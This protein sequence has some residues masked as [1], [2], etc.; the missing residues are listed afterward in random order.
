M[1]AKRTA[2]IVIWARRLTQG[3]F[4]CLFFWLLWATRF[5]EGAP[6]S[7]WLRLFF[8][9]DP[10]AAAAT[11]LA[12]HAL[13]AFPLLALVTVVATVFLGRVFCGWVCPLG[14]VHTLAS[15]SRKYLRRTPPRRDAWSR[16][17]RAKYYVLAALLVMAVFGAPWIG[18]LDPIPLLYRTTV[19]ALYPGVQYAIEDG[20]TAVYQ[21]DPHLGPLRAKSVTEPAY[22][23]LRDNVFLTK[24]QAFINATAILGIFAAIVLLNL[25]RARFWCRYVCPLGGLLGLL[26]PRP[27]LRLQSAP[28]CTGCG[29]CAVRCPAAADPDKPNGWRATECFGCWNCVAACNNNAI[30]FKFRSPFPAPS[31]AK[32]DLSKRAL[33]S[34]GASGVGGL[35]LFRLSPQAQGR[36]YNPSLI[37]PPG[38]RPEREFV[39]R[40]LQCG[41]C[42]KAC[43]TNGL[44]PALFEA[45]LEGLWTPVLVPR[46]GYCEYNCNLCGQ[47]CP[48]EAIEPLPIEEKKKLRLGLATLDRSRCLPYAYDRECMV[49]EE[50]C[51]V[52]PKAIFFLSQEVQTR[53]GKTAVLK[54]PRVDPDRCTGCGICEN[55]CVFKDRAAIRVT[56]ANETRH[57]GNRAILT[58]PTDLEPEPAGPGPPAE[59]N[60]YAQPSPNPYGSS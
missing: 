57:S 29:R 8:D 22:R 42:M 23:F 52:S 12:A 24:R 43:P 1:S 35:V 45:G 6:P 10:L 36:T 4:L 48:T 9:L 31:T 16:W 53:N 28:G 11:W 2:K 27:V 51:P 44:Q 41:A 18:V 58:G 56:S 19:T 55:V 3:A 46:I 5:V 40:C 7:R 50:H 49:C 14:T 37:R 30:T 33:L 54:Q 59:P 17:Q 26:A 20:A 34:A 47:V 25:Y 39:Q 60:P 15:W 21:A 32:L 13:P 38:A